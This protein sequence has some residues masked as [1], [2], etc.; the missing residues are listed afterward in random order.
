MTT[1]R[2]RAAWPVLAV[3]SAAV[4]GAASAQEVRPAAE[5]ARIVVTGR[6]ASELAP[7][8]ALVSVGV[9]TKGAT[10]AAALDENSA[11]AAKI[12]DA[13]RAFGIA[14][15]DIRTGQ[16]S[17][18]PAFR[19]VRDPSGGF[20]QKP[21]GYAATNNVEMRVRDLPRLGEFLRRFVEG[22][23]NR[24]GG[25]S[26]G[27]SDRRGA[28]R[29]AAAAAVADARRNADALAAAAG[30]RLGRVEGIRSVPSDGGPVRAMRMHAMPAP[31]PD[32]PVEAG[33]LEVSAA[34]EVTFAIEQP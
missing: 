8:H 13:A 2:F 20:E 27:V 7:D 29:N 12:G 15:A 6:A 11:G 25:L 22:G 34:V 30:V 28:E 32:V 26:F 23:A 18:G 10:A 5:P 17:L 3:L 4:P 31:A 33:S 21:D 1:G 19:N 14:P 9:Q 24:I 16:V